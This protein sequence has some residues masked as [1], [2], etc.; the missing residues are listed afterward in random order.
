[1]VTLCCYN[2]GNK[3]RIIWKLEYFVYIRAMSKKKQNEKKDFREFVFKSYSGIMIENPVR[4]ATPP[5]R[6]ESCN[7]G[8][9]GSH[10][11][12]QS[13]GSS[14]NSTSFATGLAIGLL[15]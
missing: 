9:V 15:S 2:G 1:M 8:G 14:F 12:S 3:L 10:S 4:Y 6:A 5:P 7:C 13:S 11:N